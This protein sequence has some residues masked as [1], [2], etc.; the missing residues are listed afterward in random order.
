M[1]EYMS[2]S[3]SLVFLM[4][5]VL[6]RGAWAGSQCAGF[7]PAHGMVT[8]T[9]ETQGAQAVPVE[10]EVTIESGGNRFGYR[11]DRADISQFFESS[12]LGANK[13]IVGARA[14]VKKVSPVSLQYVGENFADLNLQAVLQDSSIEKN[15][16]NLIRIWR[17]PGYPAT[18]QMQ[19]TGIVCSVW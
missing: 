10:G 8:I 16:E 11:F 12:A 19:V 14:Y 5:V 9:V 15:H 18:D 1:G 3:K 17:G 13:V 6:S 2:L 7:D 4:T